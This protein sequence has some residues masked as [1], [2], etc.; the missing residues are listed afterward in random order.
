[1]LPLKKAGFGCYIG[2]HFVGALACAED[3]VLVAPSA[4]PT[5]LRKM[6]AICEDYAD[7]F[8]IG[9]CFNTTKSKCLGIL[10]SSDTVPNHTFIT[11]SQVCSL[12]LDVSVSRLSWDA[13]SN[14]S[15]SSRSRENMGRPRSRSRLG[16]KIKRLALVSVSH[17]KVSFTSRPIYIFIMFTLTLKRVQF[18]ISF[19]QFT[20]HFPY[21][22]LLYEASQLISQASSKNCLLYYFSFFIVYNIKGIIQ[23]V[24]NGLNIDDVIYL[25]PKNLMSTCLNLCERA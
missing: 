10:L 3:I 11:T 16:L 2:A 13:L 23:L 4:R 9:L 19:I 22:L 7:E 18:Y 17:H 24:K 6:L 1:L 5:A 14:V 15:V 21:A 20:K 25:W 12:G 8:Y